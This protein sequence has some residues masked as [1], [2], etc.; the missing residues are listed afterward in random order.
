MNAVVNL[1]DLKI[2][3]VRFFNNYNGGNKIKMIDDIS[4][5]AEM[6][7]EHLNTISRQERVDF[8][9]HWFLD[10]TYPSCETGED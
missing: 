6:I 8:I 7:C 4:K 5:S 10:D 9:N 2:K 1:A 3:Q